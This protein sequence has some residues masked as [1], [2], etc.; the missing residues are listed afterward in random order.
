MIYDITEVHLGREVGVLLSLPRSWSSP[1][2]G[3]WSM[4]GGRLKARLISGRQRRGIGSKAQAG[5][6]EVDVQDSRLRSSAVVVPNCGQDPSFVGRG[7]NLEPEDGRLLAQ[8]AANQ[9]SCLPKTLGA[10][11]ALP[12]DHCPVIGFPSRLPHTAD[13]GPHPEGCMSHSTPENMNHF[14]LGLED[15][16][17]LQH[18]APHL[19]GA[20]LIAVL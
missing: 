4:P 14:D 20:Q 10:A 17:R 16:T 2:S 19:M 18:V 12:V 15:D 11:D 6:V 5:V 13:H 1:S 3:C 7:K 9:T 8:A